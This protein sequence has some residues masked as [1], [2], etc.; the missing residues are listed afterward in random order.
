LWIRHHRSDRYGILSRSHTWSETHAYTDPSAY[1]DAHP[2]SQHGKLPAAAERHGCG[3][4]TRG[5]FWH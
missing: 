3:L 2:G 5:R 4:D 1:A